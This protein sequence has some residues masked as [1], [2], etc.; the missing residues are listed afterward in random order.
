MTAMHTQPYDLLIIGGGITGAGI[1]RDAALRGL[2][3]VLFEKSAFG[4]GTSSKSS[5]LI[6]G[7]IRY[8]ETA[9]RDLK[10]GHFRTAW[11]NF[12]FVWVSLRETHILEK[13]APGLVRPLPMLVPL[14]KNGK[15]SVSAV[16]FGALLY[17][18]LTFLAGGRRFPEILR[19]REKVLE[20]VPALNPE[21]L[22][23]GILLWDHTTD[24]QELVKATLASARRHGAELRERAR[25]IGFRRLPDG[26]Y[27]ATVDSGG[28]IQ[29][30]E[31]LQIVNA[32]GPWIDQVRRVAG[33]SGENALLH[34]VAGS[35][36][37]FEAFTPLSVI[38]EAADE[39]AF[40]VIHRGSISRVGTTEWIPEGPEDT[41]TPEKDVRYLLEALNRYFPSLHL[42]EKDILHRDTGIR[43]LARASHTGSPS[44]I[45]RE[46]ALYCDAAGIWHVTGVKLT[47]HR[48]AAE[49]V[50]DRL[51]AALTSRRPGLPRQ[52]RTQQ[53][54]LDA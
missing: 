47:D 43:P 53:T 21:G 30:F 27:E 5:K 45:S 20:R 49:K 42:T 34:P 18:W 51:V 44:D 1:A 8:L 6:H 23:S 4:S 16:R 7:G 40:F 38:L 25:V 50:V 3:V 52:S 15:R 9:W 32:T 31:A 33:N 36:L 46:H 19:T 2:K 17:G 13:M 35:H 29:S 54:P 11:K 28:E 24:D 14:Y 39:R 10:K 26:T 37:E 22:L 41:A 12:R 48:R